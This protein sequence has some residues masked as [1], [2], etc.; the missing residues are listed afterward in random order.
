[1]RHVDSEIRGI[2]LGKG[3]LESFCHGEQL[4]FSDLFFSY[5]ARSSSPVDRSEFPVSFN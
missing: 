4:V 3:R 5:S 1:M 2:L